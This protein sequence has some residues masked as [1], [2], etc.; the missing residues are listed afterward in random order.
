M[1]QTCKKWRVCV[2]YLG[3][4]I[5][6][7]A[8]VMSYSVTDFF[9]VIG[10]KGTED[11]SCLGKPIPQTNFRV[12]DEETLGPFG[13]KLYC[14]QRF[15]LTNPFWLTSYD[16]SKINLQPY[17][18]KG[19]VNVYYATSKTETI[20]TSKG[21][22]LNNYLEWTQGITSYN[23]EPEN[24]FTMLI[25]G[26]KDNIMQSKK[27]GVRIN[28][29]GYLYDKDPQY[30]PSGT[31]A[32]HHNASISL[33]GQNASGFIQD[34][35]TINMSANYTDYCQANDCVTNDSLSE[36]FRFDNSQ[37]GNNGTTGGA[38]EAFTFVRGVFGGSNGAINISKDD[39]GAFNISVNATSTVVNLTG[40]G[41]F[42]FGGWFNISC[43]AGGNYFVT[44]NVANDLAPYIYVNTAGGS[45]ECAWRNSTGT[46]AGVTKSGL[47]ANGAVLDRWV[48]F[49]CQKNSTHFCSY[50]DNLVPTCA[51]VNAGDTHGA[52]GIKW[53]IG[54]Q[55]STAPQL[56][57]LSLDEFQFRKEAL[58]NAN[59][60]QLYH[61]GLHRLRPNDFSANNSKC[62]WYIQN[63]TGRFLVKNQTLAFN[64][65][66]CTLNTSDTDQYANGNN[67]SVNFTHVNNFE[68]HLPIQNGTVQIFNI[69]PEGPNINLDVPANNAVF[70]SPTSINFSFTVDRK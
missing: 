5:L 16:V 4:L 45:L 47:T 50:A 28:V 7:T 21:S 9:S 62:E 49:Y 15:R 22:N 67:I 12:G 68:A 3:F 64:V 17:V 33:S 20:N 52:M 46:S 2:F 6:N 48:F 53:V 29:G 32:F 8:F 10:E 66:T 43:C 69:P 56:Q 37:N 39:K 42:G 24:K 27:W 25:C 26:E 30:N 58:N 57:N 31:N 63:A 60:S 34:N 41:S 40:S 1:K 35:A 18:D 38:G 23:L 55:F 59:I 70:S 65:T 61:D 14:C 19:D 51:A 36:V 44:S 54:G 11:I 13:V